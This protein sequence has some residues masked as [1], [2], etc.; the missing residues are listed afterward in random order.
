MRITLELLLGVYMRGVYYVLY[1]D[2]VKSELCSSLILFG[3]MVL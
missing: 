1:R 2:N 3:K